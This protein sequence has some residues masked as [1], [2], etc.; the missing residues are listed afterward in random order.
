VESNSFI[1]VVVIICAQNCSLA[2][3]IGGIRKTV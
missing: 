2:V 1:V 3:E